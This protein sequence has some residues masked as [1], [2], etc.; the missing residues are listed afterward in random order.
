MSME[1]DIDTPDYLYG[2]RQLLLAGI[3]VAGVGENHPLLADGSERYRLGQRPVTPAG[4]RITSS[5]GSRSDV[6]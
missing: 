5:T 1:P 6:P 4:Q 2:T 3:E